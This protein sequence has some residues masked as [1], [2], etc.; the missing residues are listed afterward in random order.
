MIFKSDRTGKKNYFRKF[1]YGAVFFA[2]SFLLLLLA[3]QNREWSEWYAT[4]VYRDIVDVIGRVS[5]CF[6]FSVVEMLL[7]L[8]IVISVVNIARIVAA[9]V[10]KKDWKDRTK[11]VFT[12]VWVFASVLSLL[13]TLNCGINYQRKTFSELEGLEMSSYSVEELKM[14]CQILTDDVNTYT[15]VINRN[16]QG[17][18]ILDGHE[19]EQA[20]EAMEKLG[21]IYPEFAGEYP[22]PKPLAGSWILSV[23]NL[24]GVYSP[25]TVEA[26]YNNDMT[27]YNKPFTMC[28]ELS[29]LRG[30]MEEKEANFIGYLACME[31]D[32]A[33]FRY[34]GSLLGWIY[35]TN[36]LY[37][38]D[39]DAYQE[40]RGELSEKALNDLI[41]NS[42]F[43]AS[44]DGTVARVSESI[45]DGYLKANGQEEGVEGYDRMV[46]LM[47][48][49]LLREADE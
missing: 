30:F 8:V 45:N 2:A 31:S 43:W 28:H 17:V 7:Y 16:E 23:Q 46:D 29:H 36:V 3:R 40:V 39:Y 33:A 5:G 15:D 44:Y 35:C 49:Y 12:H 22:L 10:R 19:K 1:M 41:A 48:A 13:Y 26:N 6:P 9:V 37:K 47:V 18:M 38:V 24:T 25:F 4:H 11:E 20:S 42:R 32:E 34:S 21:E 14:V 27:D